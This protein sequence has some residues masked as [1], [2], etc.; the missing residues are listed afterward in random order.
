MKI[1]ERSIKRW[2]LY[3]SSSIRVFLKPDFHPGYLMMALRPVSCSVPSRPPQAA[4][5][6]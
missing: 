3:K 1:P 2:W 5:V 6:A 4:V